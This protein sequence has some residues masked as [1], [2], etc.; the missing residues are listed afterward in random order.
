MSTPTI[1]L[2]LPLHSCEQSE[3][4]ERWYQQKLS[5]GLSNERAYYRVF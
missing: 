3:N 4:I 5:I 2:N 1:D